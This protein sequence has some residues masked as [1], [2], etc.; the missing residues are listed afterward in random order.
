MP[1]TY[2]V[3]RSVTGLT[4][5]D[6]NTLGNDSWDLVDIITES[7]GFQYIFIEGTDPIE[8]QVVY[9]SDGMS[10]LEIQA[11][12][13]DDFEL[14]QTMLPGVGVYYVFKKVGGGPPN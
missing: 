7:V 1:I 2:K 6:L 14:I 3:V 11:L 4:Q 9:E 12:G 5:Q 8:Y 10:E 13:D